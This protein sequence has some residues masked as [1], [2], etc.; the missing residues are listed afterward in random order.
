MT[1]NPIPWY[2]TPAPDTVSVIGHVTA[3]AIGSYPVAVRVIEITAA[4]FNSSAIS[5]LHDVTPVVWINKL[6]TSVSIGVEPYGTENLQPGQNFTAIYQKTGTYDYGLSS[7]STAA[8][9]VVVT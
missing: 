4:G 3:Y 6:G 9:T 5:A 1:F 2:N 7:S 8:G